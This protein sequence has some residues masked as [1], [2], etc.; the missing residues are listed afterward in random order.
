MGKKVWSGSDEEIESTRAAGQCAYGPPPPCAS[1][2]NEASLLFGVPTAIRKPSSPVGAVGTV[3]P[4]SPVGTVDTVDTVGTVDTVDP[5]AWARLHRR[6]LRGLRGRGRG[7][8]GLVGHEGRV[9]RNCLR[10]YWRNEAFGEVVSK[11]AVPQIRAAGYNLGGM[12]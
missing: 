11:A 4:V 2:G 6:S 12:R 5:R 1:R 7:T 10:G 3:S 9:G 8:V